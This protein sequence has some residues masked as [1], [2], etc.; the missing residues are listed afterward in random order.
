MFGAIW[1]YIRAI[2]YYMTGRVDAARKVLDTNPHVVRATFDQVIREKKARV[3]HYKEAVATLIAQK[4]KKVQQVE[5]LTEEVQ[6][7][8][9]LKTGALAKAKQRVAQ[10]QAEGASQEQI[11]HDE[12]Y[13]KCQGAFK[14]FSSTL[15]EKQNR[16][17]AL[18]GDIVA[19]DKG[20][21]EHKVQLQHLLREID[22]IK[23]EAADTVADMITS[24]E[25]REVADLLTGLS[26]DKTN[27]ELA[28]MRDL[29][30]Q[31]KAEAQISKEL[32][33]TDTQAQEAEFLEY[34][35]TSATQDE[36]AALVGLAEEK[37]ARG[38]DVAEGETES[39]TS[40]LP[41]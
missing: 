33:G 11:Q 16:I 10:L 35:R 41:E 40:S 34:A 22:T 28:R 12:E 27:A 7:L 23:E 21:G 8:E 2:G 19:G 6:Q 13:L 17:T 24:K 38:K 5:R 31:V 39:P 32:A 37:D 30:Q 1:R 9:R 20:I 15:A 29:R 3:N 36:F 14:D 18:E 25:E 26:R 4:E